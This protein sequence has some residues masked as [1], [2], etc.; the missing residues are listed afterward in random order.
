MAAMKRKVHTKTPIAEDLEVHTSTVRAGGQTFFEV[1]QYIPSL[2]QYGRGVT[3][4][5]EDR[6]FADLNVAVARALSERT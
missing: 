2:K 3:L 5:H 1:R 4:P 6:V